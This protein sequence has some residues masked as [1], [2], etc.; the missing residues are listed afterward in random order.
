MGTG[1]EPLPD[2]PLEFATWS[3]DSTISV[4]NIL[5]VLIFCSAICV[6]IHIRVYRD[7]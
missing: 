4:R 6:H 3:H 7:H 5:A 1:S 2:L